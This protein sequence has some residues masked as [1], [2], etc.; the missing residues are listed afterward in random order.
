MDR[1]IRPQPSPQVAVGSPVRLQHFQRQRDALATADAQGDDAAFEAVALHRVH[2][3]RRQ[4]RAT[5]TDR[6]SVRNGSA[7]DI[8]NVFGK[9]QLAQAP[10]H[11]RSA[12]IIAVV[13]GRLCSSLLNTVGALRPGT[14]TAAISASNLPAA[15]AAAKRCCERS[16]QRSWSS[17][18]ILF[19]VTGP[20]VCQPEC[21]PLNASFNP[22][23]N[24]PAA[25]RR[26][27][28]S[29]VRRH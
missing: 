25:R 29:P 17:R 2:E 12:T 26:S 22:S 23:Y 11:C 9:A 4:H 5:G 7:F 10:A 24:M 20:S 13:A 14:S 28:R 1:P 15:W 3:T 18:D 27:I 19:C 16:A 8:D 21:V 6:M